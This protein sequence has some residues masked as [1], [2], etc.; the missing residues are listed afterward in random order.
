[1]DRFSVH[2]KEAIGKLA[3]KRSAIRARAAP[4]CVTFY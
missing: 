2:R 4:V 1:M 3:S